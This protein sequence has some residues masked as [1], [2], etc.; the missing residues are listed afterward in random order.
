[1]MKT[2]PNWIKKLPATHFIRVLFC[3]LVTAN[4]SLSNNISPAAK[5]TIMIIGGR[6]SIEL[7]A[8]WRFANNI[9]LQWP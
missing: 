5:A 6:K 2:T 3:D 1:M 9:L 8:I 7:D 4:P